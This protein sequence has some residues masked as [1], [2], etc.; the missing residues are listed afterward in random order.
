MKVR[1]GRRY[2][3]WRGVAAPTPAQGCGKSITSAREAVCVGVST[4]YAHEKREESLGGD[5]V[6]FLDIYLVVMAMALV[7]LLVV[8]FRN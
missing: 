2:R 5:R 8:K 6:S 1:P 3:L 7:G 4:R